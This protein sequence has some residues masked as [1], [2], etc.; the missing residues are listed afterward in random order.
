VLPSPLLQVTGAGIAPFPIEGQTVVQALFANVV[1]QLL[2]ARFTR[3]TE[4]ATG[5]Y[6]RVELQIN[7][8]HP[9]GTFTP[10]VHAEA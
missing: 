9:N 10:K 5:D 8:A 6:A 3:I 4:A 2:A 7:T 1:P